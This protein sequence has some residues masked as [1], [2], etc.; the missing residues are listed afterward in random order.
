MYE[1]PLKKS[2]IIPKFVIEN[3]TFNKA[4]FEF[5][6]NLQTLGYSDGSCKMLPKCVQEFLFFFE[7]RGI[8]KFDEILA[9]DIIEYHEYLKQRPNYRYG[10]GLSSV[11]INHHLYSLKLFFAYLETN[12]RI[13]RNPISGLSF[14][15]PE[16][17]Q[18]EILTIEEIKQLY[19]VCET[20]RDKTILGIYYGCGLRRSEGAKLNIRDINFRNHLLYVREGKG[21]KRRVVPMT[22]LISADLKNYFLHER[23]NYIRKKITEDNQVAFLLTHGGN[24]MSGNDCGKRLKYLISLTNNEKIIA[25]EIS[26]HNL[27]HSIASHLLE[28]GLDIEHVRDF[29]GHAY[30]ESTQIYTRVNKMQLKKL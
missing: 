12:K 5:G 20:L 8:L 26:L 23:K 11:M 6:N 22:K 9:P 28:N 24:R 17:K 13:T 16:S 27:R 10:G 21:C 14:P 25:K 18:R 7:E 15:A 3:S 29:L 30:L 4:I 2:S 1:S 19:S